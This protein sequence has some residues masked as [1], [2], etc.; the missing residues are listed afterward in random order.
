MALLMWL[1]GYNFKY[2][3]PLLNRWLSHLQR[4]SQVPALCSMMPHT[5][6]LQETAISGVQLIEHRIEEYISKIW[7][8]SILPQLF[9]THAPH[10][11]QRFSFCVLSTCSAFEQHIPLVRGTWA[12]PSLSTATIHSAITLNQ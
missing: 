10:A 11:P 6:Q 5:E 1:I 2:L 7:G 9:P 4:I 3:L 12:M 8:Q